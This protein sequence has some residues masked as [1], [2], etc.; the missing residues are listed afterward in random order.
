MADQEQDQA[1]DTDYSGRPYDPPSTEGILRDRLP[2]HPP[3][4]LPV[5]LPDGR[6]AVSAGDGRY[7]LIKDGGWPDWER[8]V[9]IPG[10]SP[11]PP[12][13]GDLIIDG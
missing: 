11:E 7:Y 8:P 2:P 1:V 4:D 3:Y 9:H 12:R 6:M 5:E 10:R 13:D